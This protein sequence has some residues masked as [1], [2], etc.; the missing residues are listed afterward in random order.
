M[1][2]V[3]KSNPNTSFSFYRNPLKP[4]SR[5][6]L[7]E[8][9]TLEQLETETQTVREFIDERLKR[10]DWKHEFLTKGSMACAVTSTGVDAVL[11]DEKK[12][13]SPN[14]MFK[15]IFLRV[16]IAREKMRVRFSILGGKGVSQV[17][18]FIEFGRICDSIRVCSYPF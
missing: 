3:S 13:L 16:K 7:L 14:E 9:I 18:K 15:E 1:G 6:A 12:C 5:S 4:V 2:K 10:E 8:P 17:H 11:E